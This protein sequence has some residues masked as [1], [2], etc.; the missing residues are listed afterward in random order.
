VNISDGKQAC[1]F[2]ECTEFIMKKESFFCRHMW[3]RVKQE[4][5]PLKFCS[6][7]VWEENACRSMI[8]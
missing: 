6:S 7:A 1:A 8:S 5:D 3:E 4:I 2:E